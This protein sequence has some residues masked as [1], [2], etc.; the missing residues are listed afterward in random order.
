MADADTLSSLF[1]SGMFNQKLCCG[2]LVPTRD[3]DKKHMTRSLLLHVVDKHIRYE[4]KDSVLYLSKT[5]SLMNMILGSCFLS[6]FT[7]SEEKLLNET[8]T[9]LRFGNR[10]SRAES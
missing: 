6:S 3:R 7:P 10:R 1:F 8:S 5:D 4:H 9:T 2:T